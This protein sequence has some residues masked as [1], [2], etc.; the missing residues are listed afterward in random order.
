MYRHDRLSNVA[1][2]GAATVAWLA[3]GFVFVSYDPTGNPA[4]LLTGALLL[5]LA[6]ALTSAPLLWLFAFAGA[7]R[8]AYRG[9]WWRAV[10]RAV[11]IGLVLT[12]FVVLRGQDMFSL[13]LALFVVTMAVLVELTLSLHR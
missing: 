4:V 6:V 9:A 1:L 11:L 7:R 12:I 13:P 5:G 3:L 8:I 10:R 2:F